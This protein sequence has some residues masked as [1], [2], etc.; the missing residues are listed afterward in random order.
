MTLLLTESLRHISLF[1]NRFPVHLVRASRPLFLDVEAF[2]ASVA[3]LVIYTGLP[4]QFSPEYYSRDPPN[5]QVYD[6]EQGGGCGDEVPVHYNKC[7]GDERW[8]R[9]EGWRWSCFNTTT[10][11]HYFSKACV[12]LTL[13]W[14]AV[15]FDSLNFPTMDANTWSD[16]DLSLKV[17]HSPR[18]SNIS[19]LVPDTPIFY[20][21]R[22]IVDSLGW[23]GDICDSWIMSL[24]FM[25]KQLWSVSRLLISSSSKWVSGFH[26]RLSNS[27]TSM[28][29]FQTKSMSNMRDSYTYLS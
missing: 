28:P 13:E 27:P 25:L 23:Y 17:D 21:Q 20:H 15:Q 3:S 18:S 11:D 4:C 29:F 5:N 26:D 24:W 10:L 14:M 22:W 7:L 8:G 9:T 16:W 2:Q 19:I 1:P 6:T 12:C